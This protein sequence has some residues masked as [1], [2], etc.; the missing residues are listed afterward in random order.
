MMRKGSSIIGKFEF[1]TMEGAR[2]MPFADRKFKL[3]F[4]W[5]R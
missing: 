1:A 5:V 2:V 3:R 4:P